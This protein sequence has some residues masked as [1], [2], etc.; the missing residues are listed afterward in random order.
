MASAPPKPPSV[1]QSHAGQMAPRVLRTLLGLTLLA[2][3]LPLLA[4]GALW[5]WQERMLFQPT[6]LAASHALATA[7]D[8]HERWVEVPGAR[9]SV[10]ELRLAAPRGVV[11]FLHGNAG[12][13]ASWFVNTD[14]YRQAGFDLVMMDYRGYGKSSGRIES[15]AQLHAD[16]LAVWQQVAARYQGKPVVLLGRSLGS[17]LAVTLAQQL[18]P[19][20][21]VLVSPYS[22]MR[23]LARQHYPWVP[24]ALLRYPLATDALISQLRGP[25]LL[26]HGDQDRLIP[27]AH[28][29]TL[30]RLA[31]AARLVV[32]EGADHNNLHSFE[33]YRQALHQALAAL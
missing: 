32:V 14:F 9:L 22:S 28:S 23:A 6:R 33:S 16:V 18:Q 31:P 29:Q 13:L 17:A 25:L 24:G 5:L 2:S 26:L 27:L 7:S 4:W 11:F 12:N 20:L 8:V 19:S 10:L 30:L 21:T 1:S 15:E 3:L